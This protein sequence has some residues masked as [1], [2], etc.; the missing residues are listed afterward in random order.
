MKADPTP[1]QIEAAA[2]FKRNAD[3][4]RAGAFINTDA[5][6]FASECADA[7]ASGR[8]VVALQT[9]DTQ[10][11]VSQG[12]GELIER[13]MAA[14][15]GGMVTEDNPENP[16][17]FTTYYRPRDAMKRVA[18][19]FLS[20]TNQREEERDAKVALSA[21][22]DGW[23]DGFIAGRGYES[24]NPGEEITGQEERAIFREDW[25]GSDSRR[26]PGGCHYAAGASDAL[27]SP[28]VGDEGDG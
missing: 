4:S 18:A 25:A 7:I 22:Y 5:A 8:L 12:D 3:R 28:P 13:M 11:E 27:G 10:G 15:G 9:P 14:Y 6:Y 23:L 21:F 1:E 2:W 19:L 17:G 26:D 20:S 24:D 16:R